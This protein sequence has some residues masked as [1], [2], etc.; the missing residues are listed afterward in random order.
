MK[1]IKD[2]LILASQILETSLKELNLSLNIR[3]IEGKIFN[4]L[5]DEKT[6][7]D[8]FVIDKR[9]DN[10]KIIVMPKEEE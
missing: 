5:R 6:G 7:E 1:D 3:Q 4:C 9:N 2:R 8:Y 10:Y